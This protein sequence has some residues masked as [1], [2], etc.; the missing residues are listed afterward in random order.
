MEAK[1][2]VGGGVRQKGLLC[3]NG[4]HINLLCHFERVVDLDAKVSRGALD[5]GMSERS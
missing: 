5:L 1:P 4:S 3:P 2:T